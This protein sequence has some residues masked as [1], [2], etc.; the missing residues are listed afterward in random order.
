[1][2]FEGED[3]TAKYLAQWFVWLMLGL[4]APQA[5]DDTNDGG[6]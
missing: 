1:M 2:R 3:T 4:P 5:P 6:D